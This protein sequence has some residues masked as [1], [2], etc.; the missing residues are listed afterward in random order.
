[1][2]QIDIRS[3]AQA[4]YVKSLEVR[5]LVA[6]YAVKENLQNA[7]DFE[8]RARP[9]DI[10]GYWSIVAQIAVQAHNASGDI[11]FS[12]FVELEQI[13]ALGPVPEDKRVDV[14]KN[15][16]AAYVFGHARATL[17]TATANS[18]YGPVHIPPISVNVLASR[19]SI[20]QAGAADE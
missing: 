10:N 4:L 9:L 15:S 3:R 14:I 16:L 8:I 11:Y 2:E 13:Y 18:G 1:M 5:A 6:P 7:I 17:A 19:V 12:S 20:Q